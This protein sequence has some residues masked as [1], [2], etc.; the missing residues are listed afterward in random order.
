MKIELLDQQT[1]KIVLSCTDMSQFAI[2][3]DD[4]DYD[5]PDTR[6]VILQLLQKIKQETQLDLTDGKLFIE[7][8]PYDQGGCILYINIV[9]PHVQ[10]VTTVSKS[11]FNTPLVFSFD[12]IEHVCNI[13]KDLFQNYSHLIFKSSLYTFQGQYMIMLFSFFKLDRKISAIMSEYGN[14]YGKGELTASIIREHGNCIIQDTAVE[15]IVEYFY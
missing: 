10:Q 3:Y 12:S 8:F 15:N 9:A 14:Y 1:I 4:M 5:D 2:T 11:G 13:C 7:A 6:R